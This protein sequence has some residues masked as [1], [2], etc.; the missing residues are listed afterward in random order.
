MRVTVLAGGVGGA[1]FVKG[2]RGALGADDEITVVVNTGDDLWLSGVRLQPDIDSILYALAGV[3]DT[4]RGWGRAGETERVSA[5]LQAWGAG[6]PWFTLGDLDL[7]TH[8]ARTGWL[9][10]GLTPSQIAERLGARWPIGVRLLPMTDA[11]VD[12]HVVVEGGAHLHFQEWWTRHRASLPAVAFEN[13]GIGDAAPGAGVVEAITGADV[14]VLAPSNP[15]VS[16]GPILKVPG[17]LDALHGAR[18]VVG[19]SPIIGGK[20]VRG[21]AD[22]CLPAIGVE[23]SAD[24]VARHYGRRADGGVLDTWLVAEED[25]ALAPALAADGWDVRVEPLWL[26]APEESAA[27]ARAAI[28]P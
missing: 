14:V 21:M 17:I 4:E 9:R 2:L 24:A 5:E 1:R 18:R 25:A 15:V 22:A 12:T 3:N 19:I 13:P 10:E 27:L 26:S 11:E 7:G 23:T 20:V 6:W 16:I 28:T 8:L